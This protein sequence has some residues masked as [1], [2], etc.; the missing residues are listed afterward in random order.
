MIIRQVAKT[1][2]RSG[3]LSCG[4]ALPIS[5]ATGSRGCEAQRMLASSSKAPP[6]VRSP[7]QTKDVTQEAIEK[8]ERLHAELT[9]VRA[10]L[11]IKYINS[12]T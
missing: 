3:N 12:V 6:P 5:A 8:S 10:N 11:N 1:L 4:T 2:F 9:E 7:T